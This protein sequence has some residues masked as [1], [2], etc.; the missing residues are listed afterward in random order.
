MY[1]VIAFFIIQ[2]YASLFFQSFFNHRYAA[3]RMF[4]M[5]KLWERIFFVMAWITQGSSY[6]SPKAYAILHRLHHAHADTEHDPHSPLF[7]KNLFDMMWKTK[8]RY[9]DIFKKKVTV[10]EKFK[11]NVPEWDGFD[12]FAVSWPSR[13]A[14][15]IGYSAL[16]YW[17]GAAWWMYFTLLPI[18]IV[19][20]PFHGA[21]INW[22][23]HKL[24]YINNKTKDTSTNLWP[25]DWLMWGEGLHNNHHTFPGRANFAVKWFE[26]DP[27]Y[28]FI[29]IMDRLRIIRL[30]PSVA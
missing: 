21:I 16:Y 6:L 1:Y 9:S 22:F 18:Q 17:L 13:L 28:P 19:V 27:L 14:W 3:H 23:A 10:P 12:N 15:T 24:G 11:I 25:I 8:I 30:V 29:I 20:G 4:T 2:W 7:S 26:F 5:S